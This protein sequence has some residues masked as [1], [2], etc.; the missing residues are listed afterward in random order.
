MGWRLAGGWRREGRRGRVAAGR[1]R[2]KRARAPRAQPRPRGRPAP[3]R[4]TGPRASSIPRG[5]PGRRAPRRAADPGR[6]RGGRAKVAN[7]ARPPSRRR[8]GGR[9]GIDASRGSRRTWSTVRR[10]AGVEGRGGGSTGRRIADCVQLIDHVNSFTSL[11]W[12]GHKVRRSTTRSSALKQAL[13]PSTPARRRLR[14]A[15]LQSV[16][17]HKCT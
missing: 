17:L 6:S 2:S 3:R 13:A 16:T 8:T 12:V 9:R 15:S 5:R 11:V 1:G 10:G 14:L 4:P 7:V